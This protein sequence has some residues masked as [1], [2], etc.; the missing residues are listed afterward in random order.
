MP[1][2]KTRN[3]GVKC[4]PEEKIKRTE[5]MALWMYNN[6]DYKL[7]GLVKV[8]AEKW[9]LSRN[10][11]II[12][13]RDTVKKMEEI[14]GDVLKDKALEIMYNRR[15]AVSSLQNQ[16]ERAKSEE[17]IAGRKLELAIRME[18]DKILGLHSVGIDLTSAGDRIEAFDIKSLV[19]FSKEEDDKAKD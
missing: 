19:T 13:R 10:Q 5:E 12:Y 1:G 14:M 8:F 2:K 16:L 17:G 18:I 4:T 7:G 9:N 11:I 6:P 15:M 3:I